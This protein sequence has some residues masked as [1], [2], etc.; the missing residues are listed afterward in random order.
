MYTFKDYTEQA[1]RTRKKDLSF[2][3]KLLEGCLG[4]AGETGEVVDL[5][6]K[7][8][9]HGHKMDK[10]KIAEEL[11][12]VLFYLDYIANTFDIPLESIAKGNNEK[13]KLRYPDGFSIERSIHREI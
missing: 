6:K 11:G 8:L 10:H 3:E 12:D 1:N 5:I 4:L 13:L 2:N 9:F 7:S